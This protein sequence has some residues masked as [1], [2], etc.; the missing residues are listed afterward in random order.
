MKRE[1]Y[2]ILEYIFGGVALLFLVLWLTLTLVPVYPSFSENYYQALT[3][4]FTSPYFIF[5]MIFAVVA[6]IFSELKKQLDKEAEVQQQQQQQQQ[7]I[8]VNVPPAPSAGA[9]CPKCGS[10]NEADALFCKKCGAKI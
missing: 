7:V 9:Y 4:I 3:L 6:G 10:K 1:N 8:T 5:M 2:I